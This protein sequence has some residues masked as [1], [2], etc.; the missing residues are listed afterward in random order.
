MAAWPL[1]HLSTSVANAQEASSA[2][3]GQTLW[4]SASDHGAA[5][6]AWD[7]IQLEPGVVA[8][9]DPLGLITNL[10]LVDEHGE[11]LTLIQAALHLNQWVHGVP[12]QDEVQRVLLATD[13][14]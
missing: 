4:G 12:W 10:K 6:L 5:A 1:V 14:A 13:P 11:P 7:W 9:A 8:L 2:S 3:S